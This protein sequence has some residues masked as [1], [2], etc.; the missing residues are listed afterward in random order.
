M[1]SESRR[2]RV[3][4]W[5]EFIFSD[6]TTSGEICE[7]ANELFKFHNMFGNTFLPKRI[8]ASQEVTYNIEK[9]NTTI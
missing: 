3:G 2:T 8:L 1:I 6:I 9:I 5:T 4:A 7:H